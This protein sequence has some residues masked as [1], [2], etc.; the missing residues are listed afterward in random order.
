MI[1]AK[2]GVSIILPF[3]HESV[4]DL[5]EA[6]KRISYFFKKRNI[7]YEIIV[8]Q[9]GSPKKIDIDYQC[10][11]VLFDPERGLGR[12][13]KNAVAIASG[14]YLYFLSL[15]IPFDFSDTF[16][17][18][19]LY[20]QYALIIGSKLHPNSKYK[21]TLFRKISSNFFHYIVSLLFPFFQIKDPNGTLFGRADVFK[22]ITR[23]VKSND[24]FFNTEFVYL[25]KKRG[26]KVCEVP[27][28]YVRDRL[29]SSVRLID[30]LN[31]LRQLFLL[32]ITK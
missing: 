11:K 26:L 15:Q 29:H 23:E 1:V 7:G 12:A 18:L 20:D 24:F 4:D 30:G 8:S 3:Y 13:I 9:N 28:V 10:T 22:E 32:W 19:A 17:M 31:Y 27:V 21:V 6:L 14:E 16:S 25:Y 2:N 5:R